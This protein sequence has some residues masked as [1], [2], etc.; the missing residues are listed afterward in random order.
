VRHTNVV[1]ARTLL[2][3]IRLS[4]ACARLRFSER[5]AEA[6]VREA[7]RLLDCSKISLQERADPNGRRALTTS[8]AVIFSTIKEL[9]RSRTNIDLAEVRPALMI[10]GVDE[11][12]LQRCLHTYMEVGVWEVNGNIIEFSQE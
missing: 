8:D 5:V 6:D 3:I 1:T 12:H 9:A 7:G 10:K 11:V 4:Q 2:S